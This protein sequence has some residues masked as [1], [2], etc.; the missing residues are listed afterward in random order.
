MSSKLSAQQIFESKPMDRLTR[1]RLEADLNIIEWGRWM[2][3]GWPNDR[4]ATGKIPNISDEAALKLDA[5]VRN[6]PSYVK[7]VIIDIYIYRKGIMELSSEMHCSNRVV[8]D[9]RDQGLNQLHGAMFLSGAQKK[10]LCGS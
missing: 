7:G 2:G 3:G 4:A 9:Y 10:I 1:E 6:L 5:L 8:M